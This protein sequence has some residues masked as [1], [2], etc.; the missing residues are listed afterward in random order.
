MPSRPVHVLE[1]RSVRGTGGGPEK[2]ILLS[3]AMA[4]RERVQVTVC[5]LRDQRDGVFRIDE[6]AAALGGVDYLE[7]RE[8][9]SFDPHVWSRLRGLIAERHIDIVH[10]H[11]YKTDLLALLLSRATGVKALATVH[12]WTGHSRRERLLYYP[13]DKRV[14]ARLGRLIAVSSDIKREL[15]AHGAD[16]SKITTILNAID[17]HQYTRDPN[18]VAAARVAIG[19]APEHFAIG[20]VGRLEPQKRFDL[21]MEAF[22]VLQRNHNSQLRLVIAGDGSLR[23][24]LEN[25]R[26]ALGLRDRVI[27]T[28][29]VDDVQG[30]H[31]A[32]DLFVQSSD[33]EGTPNAVLE[34]MAMETPIV[35]TEAG[36]TAELV[37]D[38]EHGRIIPIG[39]IDHLVDAIEA[40]L[41]DPVTTR[42]MAD[43]ARRRVELE[44]SFASRVRRVESIYL[45]MVRPEASLETAYA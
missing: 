6:R 40:A 34:A 26:I 10:A 22:A 14:L 23:T 31:H 18:R 19:L 43:R 42:W 30:L 4:D 1:L 12:G 35:A 24:S 5:Y 3:A 16:R 17:H 25:L 41:F 20:A 13:A 11:D 9:H 45:D 15:I 36:G 39:S 8:R 21:L 28:G 29:H 37:H 2:T 44:L 7:V 33:Y 27:L 32:F 38:G